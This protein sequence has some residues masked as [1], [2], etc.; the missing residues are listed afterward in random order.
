VPSACEYF[1]QIES[2]RLVDMMWDSDEGNA[3]ETPDTQTY[4]FTELDVLACTHSHGIVHHQDEYLSRCEDAMPP[5]SN[6][7]YRIGTTA[8]FLSSQVS[9]FFDGVPSRLDTAPVDGPSDMSKSFPSKLDIRIEEPK[10]YTAFCPLQRI[11]KDNP[12]LYAPCG[13]Q[14]SVST[15]DKSDSPFHQHAHKHHDVPEIAQSQNTRKV[16]ENRPVSH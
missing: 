6:P 11:V 12:T 16:R 5:L 10:P 15:E 7:G 13:E 9:S 3:T 8:N 4:V 14:F 2:I 1:L